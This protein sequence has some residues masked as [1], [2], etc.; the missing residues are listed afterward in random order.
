MI[1]TLTCEGPTQ[2]GK[3]YIREEVRKLIA[4]LCYVSEFDVSETETKDSLK[5]IVKLNQ[6]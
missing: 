6:K 2:C 5:M 3:T 1:I 4:K